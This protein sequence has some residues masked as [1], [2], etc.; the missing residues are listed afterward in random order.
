ME[1]LKKPALTK[2]GKRALDFISFGTLCN[3]FQYFRAIPSLELP[4][5]SIRFSAIS[6]KCDETQAKHL[7]LN[8]LALLAERSSLRS[9][10]KSF[11]ELC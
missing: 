5:D 7:K 9:L 2:N 1:L 6:C 10:L 4:T 3:K 11:I 8:G